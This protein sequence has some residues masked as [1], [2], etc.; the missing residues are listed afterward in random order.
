MPLD[1]YPVQY[2]Y[3]YVPVLYVKARLEVLQQ[4]KKEYRIMQMESY[5]LLLAT[6]YYFFLVGI[7]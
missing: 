4:P 5:P 3:R 1:E 2:T 7:E 6:D